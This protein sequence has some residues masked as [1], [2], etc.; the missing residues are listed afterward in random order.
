MTISKSKTILRMSVAALAKSDLDTG[1]RRGSG[2]GFG[3]L[4]PACYFNG[5]K[6]F[7]LGQKWFRQST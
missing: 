7:M 3:G 2:F 1:I 5:D 4:W 6:I